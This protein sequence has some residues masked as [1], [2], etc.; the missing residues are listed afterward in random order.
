MARP[1]VRK[2]RETPIQRSEQFSA[3]G[4]AWRGTP[5]NLEIALVLMLPDLRWQLPKGIIDAGET[6]EEAALREVR[7]EAGINCDLIAPIDSI[8]YRFM[9]KRGGG[10][11]RIHKVVQFFLMRYISGDVADHDDEVA[12]A[13][14]VGFDEALEKLYFQNEREIVIRAKEMILEIATEN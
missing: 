11:R 4:V 5:E 3:G 12:D 7:E 1:K 6:A 14:W 2:L 10:L 8:F 9:S 13:I